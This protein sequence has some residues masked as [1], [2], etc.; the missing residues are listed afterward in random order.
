MATRLVWNDIYSAATETFVDQKGKDLSPWKFKNVLMQTASVFGH[1]GGSF[2]Y[3]NPWQY[4]AQET[5]EEVFAWIQKE[6]APFAAIR[7]DFLPQ[8]GVSEKCWGCF[9]G[10]NDGS[11]EFFS[12]GMI[13]RGIIMHGKEWAK[14]SLKAEMKSN[15]VAGV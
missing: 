9:A 10:R 12:L 15:G 13:A 7:L 11:E 14:T 3:G 6:V 5:A 8:P 4:P 2:V 1:W